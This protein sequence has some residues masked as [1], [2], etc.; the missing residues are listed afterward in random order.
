M[1]GIAGIFGSSHI[2]EEGCL[3]RMCGSMN[4]RGPDG[5]GVYLSPDY[6][7]A[8][9][10]RRLSIIDLSEAARQPM[11]NEDGSIWITYNGEIY[12]YLALRKELSERGHHFKSQSDTEVIIHGYE[13]WGTEGLLE[14]LRGMFAFGIY[15][16]RPQGSYP[17]I[18]LA[19]DRLGIKPVYYT[20]Q[21]DRF[22]F[23]SEIKVILAS[24]LVT[25]EV[26]P[27]AVGL[28]LISGSIPSPKT[29]YK[30]ITALEPGHYLIISPKG[31]YK[32]CYYKL[33]T[34]FVNDSL[35]Q[36]SEKDAVEKVCSCLLD[37]V[38]CHLVSDVPVGAFLSGGTDSSAIVALMRGVGQKQ[39]KTF[40][41]AFP[42]HPHD[43]SRYSRLVAQV[44]ET[45]HQEVEITGKDLLIHLDKIFYAMDQPTIDGVN[46]YF[47]SWAAAQAGLKVALS[48]IGGD[49]VF[50]GYSTFRDIPRICTFINTI[51][52]IPFVNTVTRFLLDKSGDHRLSKVSAML[53]GNSDL[54]KVYLIKRGLFTATHV[55]KMLH[56]ALATE[57]LRGL[58]LFLYLD[59]SGIP[60]VKKQISFMEN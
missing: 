3:D 30:D 21:G 55:S 11:S 46:T 54:R 10:H 20:V 32:K 14:R 5:L 50:W 52:S 59:C 47:V 48:G 57:A 28:Y 15:D 6:K 9:G 34:A 2:V 17:F 23:A 43:E 38:M 13:E 60:D 29:I 19:R 37:T 39:I 51:N 58:D 44:Y 26:D 56:P 8:L 1:C 7:V 27:H 16:S 33:E 18:F 22:I 53:N 41:I 12:N 24:G 25:K 4:H 45:D 42:V 35:S 31:L 49:E 36:L 40:S